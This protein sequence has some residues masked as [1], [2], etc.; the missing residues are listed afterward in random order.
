MTLER[1]STS[2]TFAGDAAPETLEAVKNWAAL[3]F[4]RIELT[5]RAPRCEALTLA[6]AQAGDAVFTRPEDGLIVFAA[7]GATGVGAPQ[8]LYLRT[9][10]AWLPL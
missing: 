8:G 6:L 10:G 1:S 9:G 4:S 2:A 5:L 3:L 7:A